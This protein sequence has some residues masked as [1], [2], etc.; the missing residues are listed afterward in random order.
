MSLRALAAFAAFA[1]A[2]GCSKSAD[3][4]GWVYP[5]SADLTDDVKLG[6]FDT[7]EECRAAAL[8]LGRRLKRQSGI[9]FDYE[10]G[11]KCEPSAELVGI[12]VCKET[13]K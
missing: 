4:T 9:A 5:D 7:L 3:W 6:K 13:V 1:L 11:R 10:C 2:T 8:S 12:N